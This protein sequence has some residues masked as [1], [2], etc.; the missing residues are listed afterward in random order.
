ARARSLD[1]ASSWCRLPEPPLSRATRAALA[2]AM[3]A[4]ISCLDHH[5]WI[6]HGTCAGL[7][8]GDYFSL[9]SALVRRIARTA[10]GRYLNAHAGKRASRESALSAFER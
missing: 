3:P 1:R 7:A 6:K 9:A 8:A 2:A 10:F 5:E 4:K